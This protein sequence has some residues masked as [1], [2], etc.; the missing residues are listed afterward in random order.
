MKVKTLQAEDISDIPV[1]TCYTRQQNYLRELNIKVLNKL[2]E[3]EQVRTDKQNS[4]E[5]VDTDTE[6]LA[7]DGKE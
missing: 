6:A 7:E 5:T 3:G 4:R 1:R 2:Q